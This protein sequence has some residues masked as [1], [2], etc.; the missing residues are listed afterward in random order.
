[1]K[2]EAH[3]ATIA[4]KSKAATSYLAMASSEQKNNVLQQLLSRLKKN[5][6]KILEANQYDLSLAK[7]NGL[8]E[9]FLERLSLQNRLPSIFSAIEQIIDLPDPIGICLEEKQ[10]SPGLHLAK[11]QV[12]LGVLGVIYE[13]RPNV[14]I[15]VSSLTIKSGNCAL[16]RGG[17][18]ALHTNRIFIQLIQE[19]LVSEDFP[20]ETIQLIT[21][22]DRAEIKKLVCLDN[23]ID[24]IITR[25]GASL[26]NFCRKHSTVPMITGGIG[27]CHL[28]VDKT[29]N[30]VKS[31]KVII[32]AK[33]QRP[34]VCNALDTLLVHSAIADHFIPKVIKILGAKGVSFR[35]SSNA[36]KFSTTR[37]CFPAI[38]Q[39]WDTEW[40][41]LCLGIKIVDTI[42]EAIQHIQK[43][44]SGHSDGILTENCL[45][46]EHFIKAVDSAVIY[47]NAST[48]FT[49]GQE[50]GFGGEIAISTQKLHA[51]GPMALKEL[52]THKWIVHGNYQIRK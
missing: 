7:A 41:G 52:T 18:E 28:F 38:D 23:F 2:D 8:D 36:L 42:Q 44:S 15:D 30:L 27:I 37:N 29:A 11:Y 50:F 40:L 14:T 39:D 46:A 22:S 51:R 34:T 4:R 20:K 47:V 17:S 13:S 5:S 49:D 24:L 48:R 12:P 35:L 21:N 45:H 9:V 26:Q 1:M 31:L 6:Q 19:A 43:H 10:L 32:N 3:I 25:G 16:L 33:T